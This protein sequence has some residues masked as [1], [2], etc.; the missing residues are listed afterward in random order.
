MQI[1]IMLIKAKSRTKANAKSGWTIVRDSVHVN[2]RKTMNK[3]KLNYTISWVERGKTVR[4]M[5]STEQRA[6][7]LADQVILRILDGKREEVALLGRK[8]VLMDRCHQMLEGTGHTLESAISTF[9]KALEIVDNKSTI[10]DALQSWKYHSLDEIKSISTREAA[11]LFLE[12]KKKDIKL[13]KWGDYRRDLEKF[14]EAFCCDLNEPNDKNLR[15][16]IEGLRITQKIRGK[17]DVGDPLSH[18]SKRNILRRLNCFYNW[19]QKESYLP[20]HKNHA[21]K[22]LGD[23]VNARNSHIWKD[24]QKEVE[25]FT[26]HQVERII[27]ECPE[28]VKVYAMLLFFAGMRPSEVKEFR[29][30]DYERREGHIWVP[31]E[32]TKNS[33][34]VPIHDNLKKLIT[35]YADAKVR[36]G[37]NGRVVQGNS[38][39]LLSDAV[40]NLGIS[41]L[42]PHDVA[43]HSY[44][45]YRLAV[46]GDVNKL[47]NEMGNSVSVIH[48]HYR[49]PFTKEEGIEYF[50]RG[51]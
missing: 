43:R 37:S 51:L 20:R 49:A 24:Q 41:D 22:N 12:Q 35:P 5:R 48:K 8:G 19:C 2:I 1:V 27:K 16:W 3:G 42:W 50:S 15:R 23:I 45:S 44:A 17:G 11:D 34:Y 13:S 18:T 46:L 33:R 4:R 36:L 28:K 7:A 39:K 9:T 10:I 26:P 14:C 30:S 6:K 40:I 21:C 47:A 31:S 29:W 32:K 38:T 25:T